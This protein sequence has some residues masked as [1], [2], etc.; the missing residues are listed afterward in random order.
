MMLLSSHFIIL[1]TILENILYIHQPYNSREV[2]ACFDKNGKKNDSWPTRWTR[3]TPYAANNNVPTFVTP[4]LNGTIHY[5]LRIRFQDNTVGDTDWKKLN[6]ACTIP[7][8][9]NDKSSVLMECN[10]PKSV[11]VLLYYITLCSS[12][13]LTKC[14]LR[15]VQN[16][17]IN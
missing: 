8:P 13:L 14:I 9:D 15:L 11:S 2:F 4:L 5:K 7:S 1:H 12:I 10:S 16:K 6:D 17:T 3:M